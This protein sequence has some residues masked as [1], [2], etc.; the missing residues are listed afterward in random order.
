MI[1]TKIAERERPLKGLSDYGFT[2]VE[3][4]IVIVVI[5]ILAAIVITT[6]NGIQTRA[7]NSAR[8]N[9]MKAWQRLLEVYK[10]Q[11]GSLPDVPAIA[12]EDSPKER[13]LGTGFPTHA[14]GGNVPR[15]RSI[16][17]T[18]PA[19]S[20]LESDGQGIT[21][22][23]SSVGRIPSSPK[24]A[25][26]LVVGPYVTITPAPPAAAAQ[27]TITGIFNGDNSAPDCPAGTTYAWGS[28]ANGYIACTITI[29]VN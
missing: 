7:Q 8:V 21:N 26:G 29:A 3:L 19:T 2:I 13:C 23:L 22:A 6:Y 9:E 11:Y 16:N 18:N 4:L 28:A 20:N 1:T 15:C 25:I 12:G 10:A 14:G 5:G 24:V 27:W 17:V